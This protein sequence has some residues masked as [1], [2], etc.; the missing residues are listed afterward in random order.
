MT[1]GPLSLS[2]ILIQQAQ[3]PKAGKDAGQAAQ[4]QKRFTRGS[5]FQFFL[6]IYN[7][8]Q[9]SQLDLRVRIMLGAR[10]VYVGQPR[11]IQIVEGSSP[12]SRIVTGGVLTAG[13][14]APDDYTLSVTV[15][16]KLAKKGARRIARQDVD[17]TVQ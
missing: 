6:V 15:I 7:A 1:S 11:P 16:D 2:S 17:F 8:S 4:F 3:Q 9:G 10:A 14:L 5:Q 12:P 13:Q